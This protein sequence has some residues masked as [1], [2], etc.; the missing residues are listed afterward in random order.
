MEVRGV[1]TWIDSHHGVVELED[2]VLNVVRDIKQLDPRLHV[3]WNPQ[4]EAFDIVE[5]CLD[6]EQRLVFSVKEL[7]PRVLPR[8][9]GADHWGGNQTPEHYITPDD[10][11]FVALMDADNEALAAAHTQASRQKLQD[12]GERL[13]WALDIGAGLSYKSSISVKE[14]I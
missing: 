8:L 13:A 2:D 6:H 1:K 10:E 3:F 9:R 5:Y 12:A 14:D 11:D 4:S 7:D